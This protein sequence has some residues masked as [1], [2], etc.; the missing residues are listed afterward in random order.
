LSKK[1]EKK[2]SCNRN[3][4]QKEQL[5]PSEKV[6]EN[7]AFKKIVNSLKEEKKLSADYL[8]RLKYLQAD[9][10]NLKKRQDRQLEEFKKFSNERLVLELLGIIDELEKAIQESKQT[11]SVEALLKGV[12]MTLKKAKKVLELENVSP[13]ECLG[14]MFDPSKHEVIARIES[15]EDGKIIEE[16]RKGYI[17]KGKVIRPSVVKIT[18]S[19]NLISREENNTSE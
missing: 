16:I 18:V 4:E 8:N 17:M 9:F 15:G 3:E 6:I 10:E 19:P 7:E 14:Q 1:L 5:D 2:Q 11:Q 13:I 12:E